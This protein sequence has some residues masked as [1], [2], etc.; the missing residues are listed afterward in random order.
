MVNFGLI[1][2]KGI[3]PQISDAVFLADG[4]KIIGDVA[5]NDGASIWYN[6]VLRGD[7]NVVRVGAYTNIQ[8]NCTL[9]VA[10]NNPCIVG[11]HVTVGHGVILHGCTVADNCLIGMG[12]IILN[13][14]EVGEN[15]I[16][17]AGSLITENKKIPPQSLVVGA[18]G[19]VI[20]TLSAEEVQLIS[21]SAQHYQE[22]SL[23]Y[24]PIKF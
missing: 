9:H 7:V 20:R 3:H 16:I 18:P 13:G 8:D 22:L 14:A 2:F 5:I 21:Q 1:P 6:S 15:S 4:A 24:S 10:D 17:G 11:N 23:K 19:K 12:A